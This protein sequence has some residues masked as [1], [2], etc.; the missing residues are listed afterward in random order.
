MAKKEEL[1]DEKKLK[2]VEEIEKDET[3]TK[4]DYLNPLIQDSELFNVINEIGD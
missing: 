2:S 4:E 1:E 3:E